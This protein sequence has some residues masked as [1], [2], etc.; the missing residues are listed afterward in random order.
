MTCIPFYWL[1]SAVIQRSTSDAVGFERTLLN[2][3]YDIPIVYDSHPDKGNLELSAELENLEITERMAETTLV[4]AAAITQKGKD[5]LSKPIVFFHDIRYGQ[6]SVKPWRRQN[7]TLVKNLTPDE[8]LST[9]SSKQQDRYPYSFENCHPM[10][11]WHIDSKPNCNALH[12]LDI[13]SSPKFDN[14]EHLNEKSNVKFLGKGWFRIAWEI[15]DEGVVGNEAAVLKTLRYDRDF[16]DEYLD[17]HRRDAMALERLT[18]SPHTLDIY[19]YC[20]QSTVNEI[21]FDSVERIGMKMRDK[22]QY[23]NLKLYLAY[24]I[25]E[26]VADVH[27]VD[28][29]G[30]LVKEE[31]GSMQYVT[32]AT[33]VHYDL[34]PRNVAMMLDGTPKLNDF[35]VAEFLRWDTVQQKPCGFEGRLHEP[36]WRAPEEA[37]LPDERNSTKNDTAGVQTL[38]TMNE[39]VDI[40]SLGN[41]LFRVLTGRSPRGKSIGSRIEEARAELSK[42]YPPILEKRYIKSDD[43]YV[44]AIRKAMR[45]CYQHKPE[46]RMSA[47]E[48]A[49]GLKYAVET[50][51]GGEEEILVLKKQI[52]KLLIKYKK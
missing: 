14:E 7:V 50:L 30:V 44:R 24:A 26:G 45:L 5:N 6:E 8:M 32:N 28:Y 19:S 33:M 11:P 31:G 10:M 36:W 15:N 46:D 52:T 37:I 20:G 2:T 34:N 41:V 25:A 49:A 3:E 42:G 35:N 21:A 4:A 29:P 9:T 48:V 38:Q 18:S 13:T 23:N 22:D 40:Y 1:H 51:I 17:L 39:K 16:Y 12:E 43:P 27:E 47:R